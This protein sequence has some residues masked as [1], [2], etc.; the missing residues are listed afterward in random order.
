M[1][2]G[3]KIGLVLV[4]CSAMGI[5]LPTKAEAFWGH[6]RRATT[7]YSLPSVPVA[8]ASPVV[9]ASPIV[10]ARPVF[11][12]PVVVARPVYSAPVVVGY[13]PTATVAPTTAYFAPTAAWTSPTTTFYAPAPA[14]QSVVVPTTTFFAPAP[15]VTTRRVIVLP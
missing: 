8:V 13:A 7:A 11:A 10:V 2:L 6:H 14:A 4:A 15:V 3:H 9:V 5:A 12:A 1:T